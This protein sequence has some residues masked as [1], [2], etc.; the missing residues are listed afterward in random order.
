MVICESSIPFPF[1]FPLSFHFRSSDIRGDC[2]PSCATRCRALNHI[3]LKFSNRNLIVGKHVW[4]YLTTV[5][6]F[7]SLKLLESVVTIFKLFHQHKKLTNC[8]LCPS[9]LN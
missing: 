5:Y 3:L 1:F 6:M 9:T 2:C 4:E 8:P 7:M